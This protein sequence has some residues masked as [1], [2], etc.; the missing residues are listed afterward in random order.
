MAIILTSMKKDTLK[1]AAHFSL[2]DFESV[3]FLFVYLGSVVGMALLFRYLEYFLELE[4]SNESLF[5]LDYLQILC[6]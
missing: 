6:L 3:N 1:P 4:G 2:Q 5:T